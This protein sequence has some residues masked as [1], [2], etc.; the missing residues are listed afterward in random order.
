MAVCFTIHVIRI[1]AYFKRNLTA[2]LKY[3][4]H[5]LNVFLLLGVFIDIID[6]RIS[7]M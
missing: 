6:V 5:K 4:I 3:L 1:D 7:D 2:E